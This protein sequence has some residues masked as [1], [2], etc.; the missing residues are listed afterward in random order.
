MTETSAMHAELTASEP[1]RRLDLRG[2]TCPTTSDETLR[3][4]EE[5]SLGEVLEVQSDYYPARSTLPDHC[6]KRGYRYQLSDE[7]PIG[8]H[9]ESLAGRATWM[10]RIQKT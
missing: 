3:A 9:G 8:P 1:V 2:Q 4:M 6:D 10:I 5:L 7:E